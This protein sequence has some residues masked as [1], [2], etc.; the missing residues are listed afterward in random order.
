MMRS[1]KRR[2]EAVQTLGDKI[3]VATHSTEIGATDWEAHNMT[4][5]EVVA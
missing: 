2:G 5:T 1:E 4:G 3:T